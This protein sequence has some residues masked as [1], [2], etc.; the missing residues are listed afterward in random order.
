MSQEASQS[1]P[2]ED[3]EFYGIDEAHMFYVE[4]K[5]EIY[6]LFCDMSE[7]DADVKVPF[8]DDDMKRY[9]KICK[10]VDEIKNEIVWNERQIVVHAGE[11]LNPDNIS[12]K[13]LIEELDRVETEMGS[14]FR[15]RS[16]P[17]Y[18]FDIVFYH[19]GCPDGQ[20]GAWIY[21][22]KMKDLGIPTDKVTFIPMIAGKYPKETKIDKKRVLMIDVCPKKEEIEEILTKCSVLYIL[23]HHESGETDTKD[24]KLRDSEF[25]SDY[26]HKNLHVIFDMK[27]CGSQIAWDYFYPRNHTRIIKRVTE[28][29]QFKELLS[30]S[31]SFS[32][33]FESKDSYITLDFFDTDNRPWFIDVVADRDIWKWMYPSSKALGAYLFFHK[34]WWDSCLDSNKLDYLMTVQLPELQKM[35]TDGELLLEIEERDVQEAVRSSF[36]CDFTSPSGTDYKVRFVICKHTLASEV[37]NRLSS[38]DDCSFAAIGRYDYD[39]DEW[40]ISCRGKD[41]V[42]LSVLCREFGGGG[43]PNASGFTMKNDA[44]SL[45]NVFRKIK[46]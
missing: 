33:K 4:E 32:D 25:S 31:V 34:Y 42:N 27:R 41:K 8:D 28:D 37:G 44:G 45:Q 19:K 36:L 14:I 29:H 40:W 20:C 1:I 2:K 21:K 5:Q 6:D 22:R 43:H 35:K 12:F 15:N 30:I 10:R 24:V 39:T 46:N 9:N 23:D 13:G 7:L 3:V 26:K 38:M 16:N 11:E 18:H 17:Q